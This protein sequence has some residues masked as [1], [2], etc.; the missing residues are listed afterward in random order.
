[1]YSPSE[2]SWELPFQGWSLPAFYIT[3]A[4]GG[5]VGLPYLKKVTSA[6]G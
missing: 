5:M 4:F 6:G 1:M 2:E 3:A